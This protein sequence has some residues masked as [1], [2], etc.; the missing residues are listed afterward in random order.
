M[1]FVLKGAQIQLTGNVSKHTFCGGFSDGSE[2]TPTSAG[3]AL[4][5]WIPG[6]GSS[7]RHVEEWD[8]GAEH[9]GMS[10]QKCEH[11]QMMRPHMLSTQGW[12]LST[13]RC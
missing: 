13:Q 4:P 2:Q 6:A 11:T 1:G 7:R 12:M 10:T 3:L 9:T 5:G 8:R